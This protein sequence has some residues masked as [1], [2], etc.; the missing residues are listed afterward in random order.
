MLWR[1]IVTQLISI[2]EALRT[3]NKIQEKQLAQVQRGCQCD[4]SSLQ[5]VPR[6][7]THADNYQ[8]QTTKWNQR[9]ND[10]S[11][12]REASLPLQA[13]TKQVT[14]EVGTLAP[15]VYVEPTQVRGESEVPLSRL[16]HMDHYRR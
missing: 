6:P 8:A 14:E 4:R 11:E 9:H 1:D 3:G 7:W 13:R 5:G 16:R 10:F 15:H 2:N 12:R